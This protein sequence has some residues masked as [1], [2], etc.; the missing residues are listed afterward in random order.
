MMWRR[1]ALAMLGTVLTCSRPH[2]EVSP[3]AGGA[4]ASDEQAIRRVEEE[5]VAATDHNDAATLDRLF[6]PD[7]TFVNPAGI[8]LDKERFLGMMRA[9]TLHL[10]SYTVDSMNVRVYG[11]AAVVIYRSSVVG[12]L[13]GTDITSRRRRT[14]FLVKRDG[15]WLVVAQQ[16]TPIVR[17]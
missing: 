11:A 3:D 2:A 10:G 7:W 9:G 12:S 6:A 5:V 1:F 13:R 4:A 14:T 15:Q 17:G 8:L 16:S